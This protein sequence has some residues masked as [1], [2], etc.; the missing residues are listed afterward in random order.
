MLSCP[1]NLVVHWDNYKSDW[2]FLGKVGHV[3]EGGGT[4]I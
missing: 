4:M 2:T 1:V 3:W